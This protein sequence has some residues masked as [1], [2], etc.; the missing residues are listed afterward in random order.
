MPISR[1]KQIERIREEN[2]KYF[3]SQF[4]RN[5]KGNL[6]QLH[7][8]CLVTVFRR[9]DETYAWCIAKGECLVEYS[10]SRFATEEEATESLFQILGDY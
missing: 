6:S 1:A 2:E 10:Q 7:E 3:K 8:D 5:A 4:R 9:P